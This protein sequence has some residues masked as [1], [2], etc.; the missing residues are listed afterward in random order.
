MSRM[1]GIPLRNCSVRSSPIPKAKPEYT[2]ASI[3]AARNTFGFTIPQPPHSIQPAP[4]RLFSNHTSTSADGSVK[5]KKCGRIL[6]GAVGPSERV[7][8]SAQMR[9]RQTAIHR[10][11]LHLMED[12]RVGGVEFVG[13]ERATDRDDIDRQLGAPQ[14]R[15]LS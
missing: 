11:P 14:G 1:S 6:V 8:R 13:A 7:E 15:T 2:C 4:P 5:G 9:H 12:R 10:Q 3:P